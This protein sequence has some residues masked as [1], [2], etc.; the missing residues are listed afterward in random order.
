M[1]KAL[2]L[3]G[4]LIGFAAVAYPSAYDLQQGIHGMKWGSSVS[5]YDFLTKISQKHDAVYYVNSNWAYQVANQ[6][7]PG[8]FYGF[9]ND[10]FFVVFISLASPNQFVQLKRDFTA[11]Y[12]EPKVSV[13]GDGTQTVYRWITGDVKIKLKIRE[14]E[15][16]YKMAFYYE[17]L[18]SALNEEILE[19]T[20]LEA[21]VTDAQESKPVPLLGF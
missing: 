21:P 17:P 11:K 4:I 13:E 3:A 2:V 20:Q 12:G 18:S 7:I 8:V 6:P 16:E 15:A 19:Q 5:Q 14:S 9:Y 1:K 10:R